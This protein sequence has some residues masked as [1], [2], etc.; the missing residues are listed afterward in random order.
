MKRLDE[1][2]PVSKDYEALFNAAM[3]GERVVCF[4]DGMGKS[5]TRDVAA[6]RVSFGGYNIYIGSRGTDYVSATGF[7][8]KTIIKDF[9]QQCEMRHVAYLPTINMQKGVV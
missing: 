4:V 8:D 2:Y 5:N 6:T 3:S 7:C 1:M 9:I